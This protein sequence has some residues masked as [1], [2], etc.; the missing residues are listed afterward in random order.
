MGPLVLVVDDDPAVRRAL[1]RLLRSAD[2]EVEAFAS[3]SELLAF[4]RPLRVVCLVL[5]LHLPDMNGIDLLRLIL[6]SAPDLPVLILTGESD[7]A[8]RDRA[9]R[10]GA[11]AFV[12]K[13]FE[14][15]RLLEEVRRLSS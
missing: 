15:G 9:L 2:L 12:L 7:P 14:E 10:E 6:V 4:E 8:V 13:P 11:R 3:G 1:V 5:D